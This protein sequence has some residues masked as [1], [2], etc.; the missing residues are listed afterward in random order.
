MKASVLG[1]SGHWQAYHSS[2]RNGFRAE[3]LPLFIWLNSDLFG[4]LHLLA[5]DEV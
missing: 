5:G 1:E 3:F 2:P 4:A